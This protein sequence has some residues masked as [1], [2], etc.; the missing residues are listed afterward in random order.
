MAKDLNEKPV[1]IEAITACG[2][3]VGYIAKGAVSLIYQGQPL[4]RLPG[5]AYMALQPASLA[6]P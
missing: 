1:E 4:W 5:M 3:G 6:A 2:S